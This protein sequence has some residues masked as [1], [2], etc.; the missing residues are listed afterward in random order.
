[1]L[2]CACTNSRAEVP[3]GLNAAGQLQTLP[4]EKTSGFGWLRVVGG[5]QFQLRGVTKS[6][7]FY[8]PSMVRVSAHLGQAY[9]RQPSLVVITSPQ[10]LTLNVTENDETLSIVAP[11]LRVVVDKQSGALAF[12]RGDGVLLTREKAMADLSRVEI[13]GAPTYAMN[14]TFTLTPDESLYGL[15][16]Y[17]APYMDYRGRDVLLVQTNIGSVVPFLLSTRRYGVLWDVYSKMNFSDNAAGAA[18]KAESAPAGVDYYVV[19][20]DT[21]DDVIA[22]YRELTGAAP[23]FPK[24]AFGLYMSKERYPTQQRLLEVARRFREERFPFDTIVQDWQYW[25]GDKDGTWSGM[26]WDRERFPDP[27][28]MTRTLHDDL[29]AKLM[30]SIWPSVGN[31]TALAH[32]LDASG[33]RFEPLHWISGRARIYDA[34][35]DKG[36]AIYFKHVK[37]GLLDVGVDALWM[38]GTEVEVG[39]AAH[40]PAEVEADIKRL[41]RNA[42]GDFTRYLNVY[43]LLT[44]RG[45]YEGQR[46]SGNKRVF[47]LTRSAWAGQQR[48][49]ALPWSGDTTASWST[50]RAQIA[51]GLN[52]S[53]SGL[54]YW[55]QDTGGFFVNAPYSEHN[56]AYR[57]LFA[58]WNQFGIFNPIYRIHGTSIEREP[59]IFKKSDPEV[60]HSLLRAAQLR[61]Q[62]LPYIYSLA[63]RSTHAGYTMMRGLAM[64]FPDQ[65]ALRHVDDTYMFGPAFLVQPITRPM[66]HAELPSAATV[67]AAQLRTPDGKPGFALAYYRGDNFEK[68]VSNTVDSLVEHSWPGPPLA[69]LPPGLDSLDHFS[70]R[71]Q[72]EIVATESGE[73]EI[74]LEADDGV[75]LWL[76]DRLVIDD[77]TDGGA[78]YR[79]ASISLRSAQAV[80]VRIDYYQKTYGRM[81]RLAWR[82][83]SQR[84]ELAEQQRQIDPRQATLLPAGANWYD[85]W[86]GKKHAGGESIRRRY[87][88]DEFPLFVRAGSIVPLG[89]QLQYVDEKP[90][91]PYEIRIYPGADGRF[92]LYEDDGETYRYEAGEYATVRLD[93]DDA[94]RTLRIGARLGEFPG[95]TEHRSFQ[96]KLMPAADNGRVQ[97]KTRRFVG[98]PVEVRFDR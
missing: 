51:G 69:A 22:G 76:D 49:A 24:A 28:E 68:P 12:Y 71:W 91:A 86:T 72:G 25:G 98:A 59:Y 9:T 61:Y 21:M 35:S 46:A 1:M 39:G 73:Y 79:S 94:R 58:R 15:G 3:S 11:R 20:G 10:A 5:V 23:M 75:R 13:S 4:V 27:A 41:G 84:R 26:I 57:E 17:N 96:I 54:P 89:P 14:Q 47:T 95:M 52:V 88:I 97:T 62:L 31:D 92:T 37:K 16:Q 43:S 32:E 66:F 63:W 80:R 34:F 90:D 74:G 7:L 33:L 82:T 50:L 77:W 83:P 8:G 60:Y 67:P 56:A 29:H 18:F 45:V 40:D 44:T 81:L 36:R 87:A 2:A 78:R 53:M 38:D 93:W 55:T 65:A 70:A 6:V 30:V 85:F 48:Y 19:G 42:M 64:D